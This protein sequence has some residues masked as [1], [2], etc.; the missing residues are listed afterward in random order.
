MVHLVFASERISMGT[1]MREELRI[2]DLF[3]H[4]QQW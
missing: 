2:R 1:A 4:E 3:L